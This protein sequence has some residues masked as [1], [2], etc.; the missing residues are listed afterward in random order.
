MQLD[1]FNHAVLFADFQTLVL[2]VNQSP[3]YWYGAVMML[4]GGRLRNFTRRI[5]CA[6]DLPH[7]PEADCNFINY[8][9]MS[10]LLPIILVNYAACGNIGIRMVDTRLYDAMQV[11]NVTLGG[12]ADKSTVI[13]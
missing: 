12:G 10:R 3:G 13:I 2:E 11:Q 4:I 7:A 6:K 1:C 9:I 8:H 5:D